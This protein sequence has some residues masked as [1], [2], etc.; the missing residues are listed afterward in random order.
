[1]RDGE[2]P[3]KCAVSA[4]EYEKADPS[5]HWERGEMKDL[6]FVQGEKRDHPRVAQQNQIELRKRT[7]SRGKNRKNSR[8]P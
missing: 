6:L 3:L 1:V 7:R 2:R 5:A 4:S 8:G